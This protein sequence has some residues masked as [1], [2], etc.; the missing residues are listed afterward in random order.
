MKP[1]MKGE[2]ETWTG[3]EPLR[4]TAQFIPA[5]SGAA[6]MQQA[7]QA[8]QELDGLCLPCEWWSPS[9]VAMWCAAWLVADMSPAKAACA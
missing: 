1:V 5:G 7:A 4:E 2:G 9:C 8:L 6:P 3:S